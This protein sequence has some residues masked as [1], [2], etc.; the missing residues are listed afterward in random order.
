MEA[1]IGNITNAEE[2]TC[3]AADCPS[4]NQWS[5]TAN[6]TATVKVANLES[7]NILMGIFLGAVVLAGMI[8]VPVEDVNSSSKE[9][10]QNQS[11]RSHIFAVANIV[12]RDRR[13]ACLL[14]LCI[15][16]GLSPGFI[17]VDFAKVML[18]LL[19]VGVLYQGTHSEFESGGHMLA[20]IG[21]R[22]FFPFLCNIKTSCFAKKEG[23][24]A[25]SF[26]HPVVW[27]LCIYLF[28]NM[29]QLLIIFVTCILNVFDTT[30]LFFYQYQK[31]KTQRFDTF[32]CV[33]Q[34]R[35]GHKVIWSLLCMSLTIFIPKQKK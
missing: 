7:V 27:A 2:Y 26:P 23:G 29:P 35:K 22:G 25:N 4:K 1:T 16:A 9:K 28:N 31:V 33:I 17:A 14:P 13:M 15:Y 6:G 20:K 11:I 24:M 5:S 12:G 30:L 19:S 18:L 8:L 34:S 3:G 32:Y 21:G 10:R